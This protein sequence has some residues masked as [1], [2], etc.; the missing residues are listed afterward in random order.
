M[1]FSDFS[2]N[3]KDGCTALH[4]ASYMGHLE[5][6][7]LLEQDGKANVDLKEKDDATPLDLAIQ[8]GKHDVDVYL[9]SLPRKSPVTGGS[10]TCYANETLNSVGQMRFAATNINKKTWA[11]NDEEVALCRDELQQMLHDPTP[12]PTHWSLVG[13]F[14]VLL[15]YV[16]PQS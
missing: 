15:H 10:S 6:V 2:V 7:Q 9:F 11:D 3:M 5:V 4:I 1:S 12:E 16:F 8:N 13:F 14:V